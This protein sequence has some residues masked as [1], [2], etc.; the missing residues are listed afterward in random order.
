MQIV[1]QP[2]QRSTV[3]IP[4]VSMLVRDIINEL[5][6]KVTSAHL[7]WSCSPTVPVACPARRRIDEPVAQHLDDES[8]DFLQ[9]SF[10]CG[11]C[12]VRLNDRSTIIR[13]PPCSQ[14]QVTWGTSHLV[15]AEEHSPVRCVSLS[16]Q[17]T[18]GRES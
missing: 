14:Y 7:K 15:A 9:F 6:T 8:V 4:A 12:F 2:A 5:I 10:R 11:T 18:M 16:F 1:N 13:A 3:C 17:G